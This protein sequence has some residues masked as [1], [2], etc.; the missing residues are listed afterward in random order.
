MVAE[1]RLREPERRPRAIIVD[2]HAND[3]A[4]M[5]R[6]TPRIALEEH[7][8]ELPV[9]EHA[10]V[11]PVLR[12]RCEAMQERKNAQWVRPRKRELDVATQLRGFGHRAIGAHANLTKTLIP[13]AS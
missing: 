5:E 11:T 7:F 1:Q 9:R 10:L 8:G 13:A 4:R 2:P 12:A 6:S 3:A